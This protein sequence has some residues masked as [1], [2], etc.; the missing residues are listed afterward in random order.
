MMP[1]TDVNLADAATF[2]RGMPHEHFAWLRAHAPVSWHARGP[3]RDPPLPGEP[4]QRGFWALTRYHDVVAVSKDPERFSSARGSMLIRD[5]DAGR[6]DRMRSWLINLDAPQHTHVRRLVSKA[7]N[8][9]LVRKLEPTI[10]AAARAT[11]NTV[12]ERGACDFAT[13]IAG[14]LPFRVTAAILGIPTADHAALAAWLDQVVGLEDAEPSDSGSAQ[15]A[16]TRVFDYL[17]AFAAEQRRRPHSELVRG[18]LEAEVDGERLDATTLDI[19][20]LLFTMASNETTRNALATGLHAL[21]EHP[22][23]HR[24]LLEDPTLIEPAID[25][26]LR[27]AGPA[28][29]MRRT[30]TRDTEIG[31]QAIRE[32]DKVV[33]FYSS[34][35]RDEEIFTAPDSLD[36]GRHPN[37]HVAFGVGPHFC[38][39]AQQSWSVMRCLFEELLPRLPDLRG[40]GPVVRLRSVA[41][42]GIRS[43]PVRYTP[44]APIPLS[45][46]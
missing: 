28:I 1:G 12:A 40:D 38:M 35:N 43:L 2:E 5:L 37:P 46:P 4:A 11:V 24:R 45:D 13:E 21:L 42:N 27:Y 17:A 16:A 6:L 26:M 44:A 30:A 39:G 19:F 9:H 3:Q 22:Q 41:I 36:V 20:L 23:E 29:H 7:Y 10:R 33:L 31:G 15:D 25:E 34:A 18:L 14:P 8:P 32:N